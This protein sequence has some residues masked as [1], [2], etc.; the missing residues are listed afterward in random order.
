MSCIVYRS[1]MVLPPVP[2][3]IGS[4]RLS[5]PTA[6]GGRSPPGAVEASHVTSL[7][8]THVLLSD[9][10]LPSPDREPGLSD[11]RSVKARGLRSAQPK[12]PHRPQDRGVLPSLKRHV[13]AAR[14]WNVSSR[15]LQ[16]R[17]GG[18]QRHSR[19]FR[20]LV[21]CLSDVT[22]YGPLSHPRLRL[23]IVVVEV[24]SEEV[25]HFSSCM[26]LI[27]RRNTLSREWPGD[28]PHPDNGEACGLDSH[29]RYEL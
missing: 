9:H 25:E 5:E 17:S 7:L 23:S 21:D 6:D 22:A 2:S 3:L 27:R 4:W 11:Y 29:A 28:H 15:D 24:E 8:L 26:R 1:S 18:P 16:Q 20:R 13:F 19:P 10:R 12:M 14:L